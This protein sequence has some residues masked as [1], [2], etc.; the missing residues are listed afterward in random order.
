MRVMRQREQLRGRREEGEAVED[1]E[2]G[3]GC[4]CV[5]VQLES[6]S[7]LSSE[8]SCSLRS[9]RSHVSLS[10]SLSLSLQAAFGSLR[11]I[12]VSGRERRT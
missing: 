7:E 8:L 2:V 3:R 6:R 10:L 12:S 5:V 9:P 11:V 4:G 1:Q